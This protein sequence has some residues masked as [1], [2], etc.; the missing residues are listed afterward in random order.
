M[1][2][3][4]VRAQVS[5][6]QGAPFSAYARLTLSSFPIETSA[7]A[8]ALYVLKPFAT[9]VRLLVPAPSRVLLL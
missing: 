2:V 1:L 9:G 8:R 6:L 7:E 3:A 5:V 4:S